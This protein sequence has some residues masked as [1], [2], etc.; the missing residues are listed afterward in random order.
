MNKTDTVDKYHIINYLNFTNK[1]FVIL[2]NHMKLFD[3]NLLS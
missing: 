3:V 2:H 1:T